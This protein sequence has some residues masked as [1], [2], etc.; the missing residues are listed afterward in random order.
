MNEEIKVYINSQEY[1]YPKGTTLRE[2]SQ[3]FTDNFK[4]PI[5]L[6]KV[7]NSI[8]ELGRIPENN[9]QIEFFD[10]TN[11]VA[12]RTYVAGLVFL[13]QYTVKQLYGKEADI[14]LHHS[15]DKGLLIETTFP[16][17]EEKLKEIDTKMHEIVKQDLPIKKLAVD[18]VEA[19]NYFKKIGDLSKVGTLKYNTNNIVS[20]YKLGNIYNYFYTYMPASTKYLDEFA[21]TYISESRFV[22]R[23]P[24]VY[25]SDTIKEYVHHEKLYNAFE[26]C[27]DF[28]Q[29]TKIENGSDINNIVSRGWAD[30]MIRLNEAVYNKILIDLAIEITNHKEISIVLMA[31]PSSSGKTTV[32]KK[33]KTF[34]NG[35]AVRVYSISMDDFFKE[36]MDTPKIDGKYDFESLDAVDLD[37]FNGTMEKLLN[38]EEVEMPTYN[39]ITGKKEFKEKIK[40]EE[41]DVLIIEGIHA[42]DTK[43]LQNIPKEKKYKIYLSPLTELNIDNHN[44]I[45][46]TDNRLLRRIVR[47]NRTRGYDVEMSLAAWD[48]V[49]KGEEEYIFPFQDEADYVFNSGE[50]YEMGV[51]KTY[52]E[53]LLYNVSIDSPYYE[54][55][56]RL[57]NFLRAFLP[58]PSDAI[59]KDSVLR[60]FIGGSCYHD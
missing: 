34:I 54:E 10:L 7:N 30:E 24:T 13:I 1:T 4:H 2:I 36:K 29:K 16:L 21:F 41:K 8:K 12:N 26:L 18:R 45:S 40:L 32:S 35:Q 3:S 15:I 58:I 31:G 42:L 28:N 20:L 14:I 53:P 44:R 57:I 27:N 60:E 55:A 17:T 38:Y 52:V 5:I 46:T 37:L 51:L 47:D 6:A 23:Y 11:K 25:Q 43:I 9:S 50:I 19:S 22:L 33:L 48:D 39:F 59:P 49:R 56:K